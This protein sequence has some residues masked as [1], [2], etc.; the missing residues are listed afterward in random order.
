MYHF[1]KEELNKIHGNDVCSDGMAY[2]KF[3]P[4]YEGN[5][6]DTIGGVTMNGVKVPKTSIENYNNKI[7]I[8]GKSFILDEL[9]GLKRYLYENDFVPELGLLNC[10]VLD[11]YGKFGNS[12]T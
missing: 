7:T 8:N 10:Y 5:I 4:G 1:N 2:M 3:S 11:Y 9:N 6:V 12:K